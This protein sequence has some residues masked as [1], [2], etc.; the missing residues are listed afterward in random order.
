MKRYS[1]EGVLKANIEPGYRPNG[2][3]VDNEGKVWVVDYDDEY[4]HRIEPM[5]NGVDLSKLIFV[6]RHYTT[7]SMTRT[8]TNPNISGSVGMSY[9]T[10]KRQNLGFINWTV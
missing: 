2:L 10:L 9:K 6:G 4:V 7:S 5:I 8:A 1:H 3:S